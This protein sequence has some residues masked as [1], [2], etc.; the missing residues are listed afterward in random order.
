MKHQMLNKPALI[1]SLTDTGKRLGQQ[2]CE[3]MPYAEALHCP[4]PFAQVVQTAF[5][6]QRPLI[7]ITAV[8]IAVRTLAN[9]IKNKHQDPPVLVMDQNGEFIIPL[10]SGHEGGANRWAKQ[11]GQV[12][13]AQAVITTAHHYTYSG[14]V[15]G[16]GS[17]RGCP[18]ALLY[19]LLQS[20]LQSINADIKELQA[21]SSIDRKQD[22]TGLIALAKQLS[23]PFICYSANEL[24][25][26]EQY[27]TQRSKIVFREVGVYGVAEAA[28]IFYAQQHQNKSFKL[29]VPKQKNRRSTCAIVGWD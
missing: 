9:V 26:V 24:R 7:F 6:Q 8:G 29:L 20:S 18:Q 22:E 2:C 28:A 23:I 25:S 10:L 27:L 14:L 5:Q 19:E 15:A 17:D 12:L 16:M 13:N 1:I 4:K 11:L 21:I 3:W